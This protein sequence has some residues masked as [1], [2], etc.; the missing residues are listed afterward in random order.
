[1]IIK[2]KVFSFIIHC[3]IQLV[4]IRLGNK[5]TYYSGD[6][7][8]IVSLLPA[9]EYVLEEDTAPLGYSTAAKIEFKVVLS[10]D[11]TKTTIQSKLGGT[12]QQVG[13]IITA[14]G[15]YTVSAYDELK[16]ALRHFSAFESTD[17]TVFRGG[18]EMK[19]PITFDEATPENS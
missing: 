12:Y 7:E 6:E 16:I 19:L 13:D 9:G 10:D 14:V 18:S 15:E 5:I 3:K 4:Q 1:M 8:T 11:G 17:L 2:S